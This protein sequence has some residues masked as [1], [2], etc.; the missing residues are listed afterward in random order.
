M[1]GEA[2]LN[3]SVSNHCKTNLQRCT[4]GYTGI[5][6]CGL[7]KNPFD[8]S[9]QEETGTTNR[10]IVANHLTYTHLYMFLVAVKIYAV[11]F[12]KNRK[13]YRFCDKTYDKNFKSIWSGEFITGIS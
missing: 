10:E 8:K 13:F 7:Y 12:Q 1:K 9:I 2:T 11:T 6:A 4:V 5:Y 3:N